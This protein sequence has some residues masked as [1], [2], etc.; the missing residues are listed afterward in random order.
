MALTKVNSVGIATGISLTGVTTTQDTKVG[1]GITLSPDGHGYYTGIITATSY[2]GDVSNC[3]GV[4]QTNFIDAESLNVSGISTLNT[5]KVGTGITLSPDG[6]VY[7]TGISTFAGDVQTQGDVS[8]VDKI[9]HSG[10]T[11]TMIRFPAADT[12]TVE[13]GGSER[14]RID[15]SGRLG[16]GTAAGTRGLNVEGTGSAARVFFND[17]TNHKSVEFG[18]DSTGSFQSTIGSNPHLMYIDG[19][20]RLRLDTSGRLLVGHTSSE[21]LFYTGRIQVQGT[22]SSTSAITVKSNQNDSGGPAIVL[23]KSRSGSVGGNTVVQSGDEFGCIYFNGADGTDTV[24][25]GAFIR[26]SCDGTPGS[27]DMPGRLVFGTA[28]DGAATS[29]ERLRIDSAGAVILSNTFNSNTDI[30]PALVIGSSSFGRP[31]IVIRG[32]ATNKGDISWCDNSGTDSSDGVSEGLIR[33]DHA[34]DHME[35][36][37]ADTERVTI[38]SNGNT[39]ITG[40]CTAASFS[41]SEISPSNRNLVTNGEFLVSQRNGTS[42]ITVSSNG[43]GWADMWKVSAPSGHSLTAQIIN[44]GP[45]GSGNQGFQY[46][47]RY[48]NDNSVNNPTSGQTCYHQLTALEANDVAHLNLGGSTAKTITI[49]FWVKSS[50]TGT[51][52]FAM[53][54]TTSGYYTS[55]NTNRSFVTSYVIS[56]ANTW[57]YK[58]ITIAGDQSGTWNKVGTGG[59]LSFVWDLGS[60]GSHQTSSPDAWEATDMIRYSGCKNI[61][62]V[63]N[64]T[65]QITGVQVEVGSCASAF[66]HRSYSDELRRCQRQYWQPDTGSSHLLELATWSHGV[67]DTGGMRIQAYPWPVPMRANPSLSYYDASSGGNS[68]KVFIEHPDKTDHTDVNVSFEPNVE[69]TDGGFKYP[70][71]VSGF[72][73]GETGLLV[74]YR[75]TVSAEL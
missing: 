55:G 8:I 39:N 73:A 63:A 62:D 58:T 34:T 57:E 14:A 71:G 5:T 26:G 4:G 38:D 37:T 16:I 33:Y 21:A 28:A 12:F 23:G 18:A 46:S 56:S 30:T 41:S 51:W 45:T 52:A 61:G 9:Y 69:G 74:A 64:A 60:G 10:D 68:G 27:N 7:I 31:G 24:S 70:Y 35:I 36:H 32:N 49:S 2:R 43:N 42:A 66:E 65:W 6:D 50:Q 47:A 11:N 3:T 19:T 15:S 1:S 17:S 44:D 48:T 20:E 59:G 67:A 29:T 13:T 75:L 25:Q 22:N 72:S 40:I 53:G 54:N